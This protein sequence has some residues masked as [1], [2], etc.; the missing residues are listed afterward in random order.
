MSIT[1]THSQAVNR[2]EEIATEVQRLAE[3]AERTP[4]D[5]TYLDQLRSEFDEVDAHRAKLEADA[6]NARMQRVTESLRNRRVEQAVPGA[7]TSGRGDYD[8]DSILEPDSVESHRF[9]NPWDLSEVRTFGRAPEELAREYHARALSAVEKMPV[10]SDDVRQAATELVEKW[11]DEDGNL[12]RLCLT[13]S[14][15]EYVRAWSKMAKD[16]ARFTLDEDE[17]RALETSRQIQRAMSLTDANGG[18]LVPFQLDPTVIL[19]SSGSYNEIRQIARQVVA[20][21]DV[22]NGVSAGAVSWSFDAEAA[23]VSDDAPTFAGPAITIRTAR[24][25]VPISLEARMDGA[26]VAQE[27]ATLLAEGKDD[28]EAVK[29][30][31][32]VAA[33]NEPIGIV[34]ALTGT[35]S[36]VTSTT[37][38]TFAVADSRRLIEALPARHRRRAAWLANN[39]YYGLIRGAATN[40]TE[41]ESLAG[42]RPDRLHGKP[43]YEAEAMD[44]TVTALADNYVAIVGDFSKYVI[45]D[46]V[47]MTVDFI[48][49]LFGS[50]QRP[51]GQS[52]W[53]AYYRVGAASVDDNA[54]RMLNIT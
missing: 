40:G 30:I 50:N 54:F 32:G 20:T 27:V 19:T 22:W 17:R 13:I 36:V 24:G 5:E 41:W 44:G 49:H 26:N 39:L 1:L 14:S 11:D 12:A 46:R 48:P 43:V 37:T 45:A 4:E 8:R 16:P 34:T 28:L 21:G 35:A 31:T 3:K 6:E 7:A 53:F 51:T 33:S 2:L 25:F 18:Y 15:P 52:G 23:E 10:A 38:D 42:D 47:G 29:F 9:R